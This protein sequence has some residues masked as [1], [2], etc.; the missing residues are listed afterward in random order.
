MKP[1]VESTGIGSGMGKRRK[2][3]WWNSLTSELSKGLKLD[4]DTPKKT[5]P[6]EPNEPESESENSDPK[7]KL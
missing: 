2:T 1:S 3:E 5:P 7:Q 4:G 6:P